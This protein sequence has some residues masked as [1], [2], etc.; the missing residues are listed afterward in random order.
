MLGHVWNKPKGQD[1]SKHAKDD[2]KVDV[3]GPT[4][5]GTTPFHLACE[6]GHS[7]IAELLIEELCARE[8]HLESDT[9]NKVKDEYPFDDSDEDSNDDSDDDPSNDS[10][11][12]SFDDSE[13]DSLS[14]DDWDSDYPNL[15]VSTAFYLACKN[16]HL[17]IAEMFIKKFDELNLD[18]NAH[19]YH[20]WSDNQDN[21]KTAFHFA[22]EN[23]HLKIVELFMQNS[24][25]LKID[26]NAL[27]GDDWDDS[28]GDGDDI[29][30]GKSAFHYACMNSHKEIVE[31]F[32]KNS[33]KLNI[34]LNGRD[35]EGC[36]PFHL[37]CTNSQL[38]IALIFLNRSD[39][40]NIGKPRF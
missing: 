28:D 39:V 29:C 40:Q 6:N 31:M 18:L 15:G 14:L 8:L 3:D 7:K 19:H 21:G 38:E 23:G 10:D 25:A 5:I 20:D 24:I 37:A 13:I 9:E 17:A 1:G 4:P 32:M 16:G 26:L 27:A 36:T 11:D 12:D 30:V 33:V 2:Y 35:E 22:C 34:N